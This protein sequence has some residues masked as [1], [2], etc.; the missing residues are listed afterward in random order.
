MQKQR[1]PE[2]DLSPPSEIQKEFISIFAELARVVLLPK[3]VGE[4]YGLLY[5]SPQPLAVPEIVAKLDISKATVSSS[6][7]WLHELHAITVTKYAGVRHD[8]FSAQTALRPVAD[9][10]IEEHL[11]P[12][13]QSRDEQIKLLEALMEGRI[14]RSQMEQQR[15]QNCENIA[16]TSPALAKILR[17][18]LDQ[19]E[20]MVMG[21]RTTATASRM[22]ASL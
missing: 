3:S 21:P 4:I 14:N 1:N 6:M 18:D 22:P 12:G 10:I 7:R 20:M 16:R 13:M 9:K 15:A 19:V 11:I 5:G 2:F 17:R 8:F